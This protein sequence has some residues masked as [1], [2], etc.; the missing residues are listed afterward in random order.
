[1]SEVKKIT[2]I[3]AY[4][5]SKIT[6]TLRSF[7]N[8]CQS[9]PINLYGAYLSHKT[10]PQYYNNLTFADLKKRKVSDTL[11]ILGSGASICDIPV[12]DWEFM[13]QHNTMSFNYFIVQKYVDIDFHIIRELGAKTISDHETY[14]SYAKVIN[15]NPHYENSINIVQGGFRAFAGNSFIGKLCLR[16]GANVF[17]FKNTAKSQLSHDIKNGISH[18]PGTLADCI[19]LAY[20]IGFKDIVLVGVDLY[21]RQYFWFKDKN[22]YDIKNV[23]DTNKD[24]LYTED[25]TSSETHRTSSGLIPFLEKWQQELSKKEV[26]LYTLNPKSLLKE[27]CPVYEIAKQT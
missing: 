10:P 3:P 19:N 20:L 18:G 25:R 22:I 26:K 23:T 24:G 4:A 21:D 11:F 13:K 7:K 8:K 27:I 17:R 6:D 2:R 14:E 15:Q 12:E 5:K 16:R 1:M 9:F